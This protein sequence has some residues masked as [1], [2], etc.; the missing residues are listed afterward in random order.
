VKGIILADSA[1]IDLTVA[2]RPCCFTGMFKSCLGRPRAK[3]DSAQVGHG[4]VLQCIATGYA[5]REPG[6]RLSCLTHPK[7][8]VGLVKELMAYHKVRT[9]NQPKPDI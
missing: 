9:L 2:G 8:L 1:C 5:F 3:F 7:Y 6:I 4:S